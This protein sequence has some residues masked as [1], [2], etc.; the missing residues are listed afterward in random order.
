MKGVAE[1]AQVAHLVSYVLSK[2]RWAI[3]EDR[4][5]KGKL[6]NGL[7]FI[8][9]EM[10]L[11]TA[12]VADNEEN[13]ED[14]TQET[15]ILQL[16]ELAYDIEDFIEGLSVPGGG[17][18]FILTAMGMDSR[19]RELD[20][21]DYFKENIERLRKW[22]PTAIA[23]CQQHIFRG[24]T[25]H[26]AASSPGTSGS[27]EPP[28]HTRCRQESKLVGIAKPKEE[29]LQLLSTAASGGR[30]QQLRVVS[31]VGRRGLGKTTLARVVYEDPAVVEQFT[32]R[33]WVV[34]S[35]CK[36]ADPQAL[37]NRI[38]RDFQRGTAG[39]TTT[40]L[41]D[42]R[43]LVVIDD[44]QQADVWN[45][46]QHAFP[47]NDTNSRI[48]VTTRVR[49]LADACSSGGYVYEMQGIG[50]AESESLFWG[51][52]SNRLNRSNALDDGLQ[53]ILQKCDGLPL[54][55]ISVANHLQGQGH[56]MLVHD[57]KHVDQ[58]LGNYL[59]GTDATRAF[60]KIRRALAECYDNLPDHVHRT[61][62]LSTS[63][64]PKGHQINRK[65]L[66][67]KLIAEGLVVPDVRLEKEDVAHHCL[68]KLID[69][70]IIDPILIGVNSMVKRC[71]VHGIML[72]FTVHKSVYKNFV[73]LIHNDDH[74][75]KRRTP[76]PIRR[77]SIHYGTTESTRL[78]R[79]MELSFI[80][81]LMIRSS[82]LIDFKACRLLRVLDLEGC[83]G[84][85]KGAIG[86]IC[87]L[88]FL[89]YLSLRGSDVNKI[90]KKVKK[91]QCLETLDIRETQVKSLPIEIIMLPRLVYL[92]G[93]FE[94]PHL[95][96]ET[97]TFFS[98]DSS[99]HTL[100]GVVINNDCCGLE[101]IMVHARNLKKVKIWYKK[102]TPSNNSTFQYKSFRKKMNSQ[103][104]DK[105]DK[106]LLLSS[107]EERFTGKKALE[108]ISID[109][110]DLAKDFLS[111]LKA[112]CA[113]RSIKLQGLLGCLPDSVTLSR[114]RL[115]NELHLVSTG[116]GCEALSV[117]QILPCLV[118]LNLVESSDGLWGGDFIVQCDGFPSLQRLRF[119]APKL[120]KV[121]IK[122]GA[123]RLLTSLQLFCLESSVTMSYFPFPLISETTQLE[124]WLGVIG[125]SRLEH[126]NEVLLHS[127]LGDAKVQAWKRIAMEHK[128]LPHVRKQSK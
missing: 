29:I 73:T 3:E 122:Q 14:A 99:L 32:H 54:A 79:E 75:P 1:A 53:S 65:S 82:D 19:P 106:S 125:I 123:L 103:K 22:Q 12:Q 98:E 62:L 88:L 46:I 57:C 16:Q 4:K 83:K 17:S 74:L 115:L 70:N 9:G 84:L 33:A 10:E 6:K 85:G 25:D 49:S 100:A 94:L 69:H 50:E 124:L 37:L 61:C 77:L 92:F 15:R 45:D 55:V 118:Y 90:T 41:P 121:D 43:Y 7:A 28:L 76:Y 67:R 30:Q 60:Q 93:Q 112:P 42:K 48:I 95:P 111:F 80:R 120:P 5:R 96:N 47:Q 24:S 104:P 27:S 52:M 108:S 44:L 101:Q 68:N 34:A 20:R 126:L 56:N 97:G 39:T 81:W 51:R 13:L 18:G 11:V 128:N 58:A 78:A 40:D 31:I 87:E 86:D 66:V 105:M 71:Q 119:Q 113:I 63:M 26:G 36:G 114:L 102:T 116:L 2:V 23:S 109:S 38:H 21:I 64:F 91:L 8:K 72:E 35:G 110:S 59:T 107:I 127:S 89:K 117:L